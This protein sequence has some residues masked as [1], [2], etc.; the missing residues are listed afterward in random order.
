MPLTPV[1]CGWSPRRCRLRSWWRLARPGAHEHTRI[2]DLG[3][4]RPAA[5]LPFLQVVG[6]SRIAPDKH[7]E[8]VGI[9]RDLDHACAVQT[10]SVGATARERTSD[11]GGCSGCCDAESNILSTSPGGGDQDSV[12]NTSGASLAY[13]SALAKVDVTNEAW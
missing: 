5:I 11:V 12:H 9:P 8:S 10:V 4:H 1:W 13:I 3:Q 6:L 2:G 7:L